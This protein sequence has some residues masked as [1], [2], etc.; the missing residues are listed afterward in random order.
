VYQSFSTKVEK[1]KIRFFLLYCKN[2]IFK[3]LTLVEK[4]NGE[5]TTLLTLI[6]KT[7]ISNDKK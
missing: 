2:L 6:Q 7:N 5:N 3:Q 1:I 4:Y